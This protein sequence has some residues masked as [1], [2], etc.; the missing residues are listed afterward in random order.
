MSADAQCE[1][2]PGTSPA[3]SP[4]PSEKQASPQLQ[5]CNPQDLLVNNSQ[6]LLPEA[7]GESSTILSNGLEEYSTERRASSQA[8]RL[9]KKRRAHQPHFSDLFAELAT[10]TEVTAKRNRR[11]RRD[12]LQVCHAANIVLSCLPVQDAIRHIQTL[13]LVVAQRKRELSASDKLHCWLLR[14]SIRL[15]LSYLTKEQIHFG[16]C[17]VLAAQNI[18]TAPYAMLRNLAAAKPPRQVSST[19]KRWSRRR[20]QNRK[21]LPYL[22]CCPAH[23]K[24]PRP[25]C[26]S[27]S[28][29]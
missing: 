24:P 3:L 1:M 17:S 11:T 5:L 26:I 18:Y 23:I 8:N 10:A 20:S 9:E 12:I 29:P 22:S 14:V 28:E 19:Q 21:P 13:E 15:S 2:L 4:K 16:T 6:T 7:Y 27:T 25:L